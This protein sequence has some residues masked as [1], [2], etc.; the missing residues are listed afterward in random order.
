M[1]TDRYR[2]GMG[3]PEVDVGAGP[4]ALPAAAER[5]ALVTGGAG[6][7]GSHLVRALLDSGR[8]VVVLDVRRFTPEG[9]F[10]VGDGAAE[11]PVEL[12]SIA[13]AAR[14]NDVVRVHQPH[15]IVHL[16]MISTPRCRPRTAP[17]R[18]RATAAGG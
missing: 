5:T 18:P 2:E 4:R 14:L 6:F 7:I 8:R 12:G 13:D 9:A 15:E 10:A 16:G 17:M 1:S 11:V 3:R